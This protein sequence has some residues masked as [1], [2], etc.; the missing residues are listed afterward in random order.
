MRATSSATTSSGGSTPDADASAELACAH[1]RDV[2]T[3]EANGVLTDAELRDKL[4]EVYDKARYSTN[5]GIPEGAQAMLAAVTQGDPAGLRQGLNA[6]S[7]A[8]QRVGQ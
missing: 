6:F 3:D 7:A 1:F 4:K 8:C 2:V 5:A